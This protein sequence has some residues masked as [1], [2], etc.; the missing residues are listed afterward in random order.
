MKI[1]QITYQKS[2]LF[3]KKFI[4]IVGIFI[5][6]VLVGSLIYIYTSGPTLSQQTN[7]SIETAIKSPLPEI[8][9]GKTGLAQ[10]Q[11]LH[12]WYESRSPKETSKGA[13]LL[14]MG[15][16]VDA[17]GWTDKFIQSFVDAGYQ[18]IRYDNRGTGMSDWVENWDNAH[19]YSLADMA[20]D[21]VAVLDALGIPKAHIVGVSMGGMIGQ[22][23]T[24]H[25][26][27]RV[28]SLTSIMSSGYIEDPDLP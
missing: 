7:D 15:I 23:L 6:L 25:H 3:L 8:V 16:T 10:S 26:P 1:Y 12:I 4:K 9:T 21:G 19:P 28:A 24:I 22:E 17:L 18:V 27:D 11:G 20:E 13:I 14:I 5:L 2:K